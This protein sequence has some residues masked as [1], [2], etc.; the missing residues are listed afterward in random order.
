MDFPYNMKGGVEIFTVG[1]T[2]SAHCSGLGEILTSRERRQ[3]GKID[4]GLDKDG[5]DRIS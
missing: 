4:S 3:G 1:E 2:S 5:M